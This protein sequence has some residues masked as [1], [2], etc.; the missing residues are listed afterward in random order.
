MEDDAVDMASDNSLPLGIGASAFGSENGDEEDDVIP[1]RTLPFSLGFS[2]PVGQYVERAESPANSYSS[3]QSDSWSETREE[4]EPSCTQVLLS[5]RDSSA[6]SSEEFNSDDE[7][8]HMETSAEESTRKKSKKEGGVKQHAPA[9]VKPELVVDPNEKR[10]PAMTVEFAFKALTSCLKK[11]AED[12]LKYFKKLLW[13]RYPERFRD[14]LD[15]LDIVDLVDKMLELCDI[16]IS[17]KITLALF[18]NMSFK[19]LAEYLQGLCKRNEVRYELKLTLKRKYEMVYEGFN[20][21]GQPVPFESVYTD[22][23]ISDG[24]SAS[25]NSEHEFRPKIEELAESGKVKRAPLTG[26]DIFSQQNVRARQVRSVLARGVPGCGKSFAVQRFI[27]DWVDGKVHTDVFFLIP[28]QF[29]E[30]N[31]ML[32][33]EYTLMSLVSILYPEMKEIDTLDF[34]G[35]P[36]MFICDGL[37]DTQIPFNFRRTVYWCDVTRPATVQV[38]MTNLI[39]GN[40]LYNAYVWLISRAGS[41]DVIPPEHVHQLLLIRGFNNDQKEAYFRKNISDQ[42]LAEKVIAHIKSSKTLFIMCHSPLFCWVA[43]K[44][45]QGQFQSLRTS[46]QLPIT[47]TNLYTIILHGH[48]LMSIEKLKNDP[49]K[50]TKDLS[51]DKLLI[52]LAK[53]SYMMLEKNEFQIEKEHWDV[54]GLADSYPAMACTGLCTEYYR[55]KFMIYTEK[56]SCFAQPTIQEYLAA[57]HVFYYFKKHGKNVLE[58]SKLSKVLKVSLSDLLR[59]AVDKALSSKNSNY[60]LFLRFLLGLSVEANQELLKNILQISASSSLNAREETSRYINKKIKEGHFPEKTE[61]LLRCIDELNP[62]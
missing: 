28:L 17:L 56:V 18:N 34:E 5:R 27:L 4:H 35:C 40:L 60:D 22:L 50:D 48:T 25:I 21:Q 6:S 59:S 1:Q 51:A 33:G 61:N 10:H 38:L 55:E 37:D 20:Q 8:I 11:L 47:L 16:E 23:Y 42:D 43:S 9:P 52:K 45:L 53:L 39:R 7:D 44:V 15:G 32:E 14:P 26:N 29:K 62:Q 19:K 3:M 54:V 36:V 49:T 2:C 41:L 13:E 57:L 24:V 12:E 46:A 30:L 31:K 58:Q